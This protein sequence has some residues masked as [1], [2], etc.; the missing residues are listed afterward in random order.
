[1]DG[2][3]FLQEDLFENRYS[4]LFSGGFR[5]TLW[6]PYDPELPEILH[7]Y[8]GWLK[9]QENDLRPGQIVHF[10]PFLVDGD[11]LFEPVSSGFDF[12]TGSPIDETPIVCPECEGILVAP[13]GLA[14]AMAPLMEGTGLVLFGGRLLDG[15][16]SGEILAG[17][18]RS[19]EGM[20][21]IPTI[22]AVSRMEVHD[23]ETP[24]GQMVR[25]SVDNVR[26]FKAIYASSPDG[27][28]VVAL[29]TQS[30]AVV[31]SISTPEGTGVLAT[32]PETEELWVGEE[33]A[34]SV[35]DTSIDAL[36]R[37]I[38]V[39]EGL[40]SDIAFDPATGRG[41][42][43]VA[44]SVIPGGEGCEEP[45]AQVEYDGCSLP[46]DP[47]QIN[48]WTLNPGSAKGAY[49]ESCELV[50]PADT[51]QSVIGYSR[52]EPMLAVAGSYFIEAR[53]RIEDFLV[54]SEFT[55][56]ASFA[57]GDGT[58]R[59]S[60]FFTEATPGGHQIATWYKGSILFIPMDWSEYHVYRIEVIVGDRAR[61]LV[62][63]EVVLEQDYYGFESDPEGPGF[64]YFAGA[65]SVSRW[66]ELSYEICGTSP[67][68]QGTCAV[69]IEP[70][71]TEVALGECLM[72]TAC[73]IELPQVQDQDALVVCREPGMIA[74]LDTASL[75]F[76]NRTPLGFEPSGSLILPIRNELL[77]SDD[78]EGVVHVFNIGNLAAIATIDGVPG[79]GVMVSAALSKTALVAGMLPDGSPSVYQVDL[80]QRVV[81]KAIPTS[82]E[83]SSMI[84]RPDKEGFLAGLQGSSSLGFIRDL[85]VT[86]AAAPPMAGMAMAFDRSRSE[87][88]VFGGET[89]SGYTNDLWVLEW[90]EMAWRKETIVSASKTAANQSKDAET[91]PTAR[92]A[93]ASELSTG[94]QTLFL[95]GGIGPGG[96]LSDI[97]A[98]DLPNR[99]FELLHD[100]S[101]VAPMPRKQPAL[102]YLAARNALFM[103]G[104]RTELGNTNDTWLF[105][106][107]AKIWT[108]FDLDCSER[109]CPPALRNPIAIPSPDGQRVFLMGGAS[110]EGL[111]TGDGWSIEIASGQWVRQET[112]SELSAAEGGLVRV[113]YMGRIFGLKIAESFDSTPLLGSWARDTGLP[114]SD[115]W[116]GEVFIPKDGEYVFRIRASGGARLF[117]DEG[118][119]GIAGG[120]H[121]DSNFGS[122]N[123]LDTTTEAVDLRAGWHKI[124][125]DLTECRKNV[126]MEVSI[127]S[128]P[129]GCG[130]LTPESFRVRSAPALN[131]RCNLALGAL[132]WPLGEDLDHDP[133]A[134]SWPEGL[135]ESLCSGLLPD[136]MKE[137]EWQGKLEVIQAGEYRFDVVSDVPVTLEVDDR[138]LL[139]SMPEPGG[140][141]TSDAIQLDASW[142]II[143]LHAS[144]GRR[145]M[146]IQL[147]F[148]ES[149]PVM[150]GSVVPAALFAADVPER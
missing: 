67:M 43:L 54:H 71:S 25:P 100:G 115:R 55:P 36:T 89:E 16:L 125:F 35:V 50:L 17:S 142:H 70:D 68:T 114:T 74:T 31:R 2:S 107:N 15:T 143:R 108:P 109:T 12:D 138:L 22:A 117:L 57:V 5:K 47:N 64:T 44:R 49:V 85:G 82:H 53:L 105:D 145:P 60:L 92:A 27:S 48:P 39:G 124:A 119:I 130:A 28:Q 62:D 94:Q 131:R 26:P 129:E 113:Q 61:F 13:S 104:G 37:S 32:R 140:H 146:S 110:D 86:P 4:E 6:P 24:V 33:G 128:G 63:G 106:L 81:V 30:M 7:D 134:A 73:Q 76:A 150:G 10:Y 8:L 18:P 46:D 9:I 65:E 135:P 29:D 101:G 123:T 137:I 96:L 91:W 139:R 84:A 103:F 120:R 52:A 1:M 97:W 56:L 93:F 79:A 87:M 75:T 34:V 77:I 19:P 122:C 41:L 58:V 99:S 98:L 51:L 72:G 148:S 102:A 3:P 21:N 23:V 45:L 136:W 42:V 133:I 127:E 88:L 69:G 149:C 141:M 78:A 112:T 116:H 11:L 83:V 20:S 121:R 147:R 90:P 111:A 144:G 126:S 38:D 66:D 14:G 95:Y 118:K 132:R 80:E 59:A 40:V